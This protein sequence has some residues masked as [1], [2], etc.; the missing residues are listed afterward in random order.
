MCHQCPLNAAITRVRFPFSS[1]SEVTLPVSGRVARSTSQ[2]NRRFYPVSL[3][4]GLFLLELQARALSAAHSSCASTS[5]STVGAFLG[6]EGV[7]DPSALR[8]C[9][10]LQVLPV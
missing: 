2:F 9:K 8:C 1:V 3:G 7:E 5:E 6:V 10:M 4:R